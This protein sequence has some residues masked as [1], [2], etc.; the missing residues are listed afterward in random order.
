MYNEDEAKIAIAELDGYEL[1]GLAMK[2]EVSQTDWQRCV[3][4]Y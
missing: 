1:D 4:G 3:I 2:V